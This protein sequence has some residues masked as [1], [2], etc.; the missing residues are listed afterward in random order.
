M[1]QPNY[2]DNHLYVLRGDLRQLRRHVFQLIGDLVFVTRHGSIRN[3]RRVASAVHAEV[4]LWK[5]SAS[6]IHR[7]RRIALLTLLAAGGFA[8]LALK[9]TKSASARL[10]RDLNKRSR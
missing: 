2:L 6:S 7:R 1:S 4:Y 10:K 8:M 9:R 5:E 3:L